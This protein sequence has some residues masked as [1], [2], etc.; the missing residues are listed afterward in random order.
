MFHEIEKSSNNQLDAKDVETKEMYKKHIKEV[1]S[2]YCPIIFVDDKEVIDWNDSNTIEAEC[3]M[4][5]NNIHTAYN[6]NLKD[7]PYPYLYSLED[8][9]I[10]TTKIIIDRIKEESIMSIM[11]F[12]DNIDSI[13][14][15]M[16]LRFFNLREAIELEI[17][18][19]QSEAFG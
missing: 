1:T 6:N 7:L 5:M 17:S 10:L 4:S 2:T 16:F 3:L 9:N 8:T 19:I 12:M 15:N 11:S 14:N 18:F 13:T